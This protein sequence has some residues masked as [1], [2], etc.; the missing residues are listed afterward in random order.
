MVCRMF[1][2]I[3]TSRINFFK[4]DRSNVLVSLIINGINK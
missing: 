2:K 4:L 3:I 1:P